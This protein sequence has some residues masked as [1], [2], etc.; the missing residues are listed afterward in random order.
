MPSNKAPAWVQDAVFY[1]IFLDR[2]ANGDPANDPPGVVPWGT[3]PTRDNFCGGDLQGI[4]DHLPYLEELGVTALY[5]TPI[6]KARSN[7]KY[8]TCDY[9]EVDPA[10]GDLALL[11]KL[12]RACHQRGMHVVLDA[13][14]NHC[15]DG[16][17]AFED[18]I[19]RGANSPYVDWFFPTGFPIRQEPPNYQT[20]GGVGFL[21]SLT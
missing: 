21:P 20:C 7:H 18:L 13:V 3:S 8:D 14:F 16:F 5:L 6:F 10:F 1:Q 17:W 2:F 15:G 12:V 11:R 4:L 9:R 19:H